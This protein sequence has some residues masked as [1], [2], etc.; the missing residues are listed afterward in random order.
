MKTSTL[1]YAAWAST[2][3]VIGATDAL[4]AETWRPAANVQYAQ[5]G[6]VAE[7]K[8]LPRLSLELFS[9][10]AFA[11]GD[12]FRLF[13]SGRDVNGGG[14][15]GMFRLLP[16]GRVGLSARLEGSLETSRGT[17]YEGGT[18]YEANTAAAGLML[19]VAV[20]KYLRPYLQVMGGR[21][22]AR[23]DLF[24]VGP[25]GDSGTDLRGEDSVLFGSGAAG[26]RL[27]TPAKSWWTGGP[28]LAF[29]VYLEGG[30]TAAPSFD[31]T[32]AQSPSPSKDDIPTETVRLGKL[33]RSRAHSR[34][35][36]AVHF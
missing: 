14:I 17:S 28:G 4:A 35:G 24:N 26:L 2:A 27:V 10:T 11:Q 12:A 9:H 33:E 8:E 20:G 18:K 32:L 34:L 22:S 7:R 3:F 31:L 19:D 1:L 13:S 6:P 21:A 16:A 30:Y 29:S 36:V 25:A 15:A 23:V 5:P